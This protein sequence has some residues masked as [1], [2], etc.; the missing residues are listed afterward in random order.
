VVS[1]PDG[2]GGADDLLGDLLRIVLG[3]DDDDPPAYG[4]T[5]TNGGRRTK[6]Q[7]ASI[8]N[9]LWRI[10]R[11]DQPMTVRQVFYRAVSAGLVAKT[12]A[13][14]KT[15]VGRLLVEMRRTGEMPYGWIADNTRW[16][17]KPRTWHGLRDM[18]DARAQLYR[19]ALWDSQDCRCEVWLEKDA[20]A[21]VVY[22]VTGPWDV[23]L[24][25]TRGY[26]SLSFLHEAAEAIND[27]WK[28]AVIF[29]LGDHDPS[30]EDI[31]RHVEEELVER[32]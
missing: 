20:L 1:V 28:D 31:P 15:T 22:D 11:A 26:P 9:G 10:V 3:G 19:R 23:P 24:M 30:G 32:S 18:L 12:E 6:A 8:R 17:R 5:P 13:E 7:M 14:Y 29:Y 16:M 4:S 21:G 25:V 27:D 2:G